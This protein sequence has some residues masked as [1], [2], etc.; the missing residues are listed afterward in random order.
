MGIVFLWLMRGGYGKLF[1][2]EKLRTLRILEYLKRRKSCTIA[3]LMAEFKVSS[4]TIH[5]DVEELSRRDAVERVR[6][7]LVFR[8]APPSRRGGAEFA[9][10]TVTNHAAKIAVARKALSHVTEGDILFL[11]SSTTVYELAM[12]L[13]DADFGHL[14]IVTNSVSVIQHFR[15]FPAHWVLIGLGGTYDP[16]L[17]SILG[18]DALA[19]VSGVNITKAF[20]SAFGLAGQIVTTNHERQAELIRKVI[21]SAEKNYLL[22]DKSKIG[23]TGL[24]RLASRSAFAEVFTA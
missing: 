19:Q 3:E 13:R 7:G 17:N 8:D 24:Y 22:L 6:G 5:R 20:F 14:T 21:A 1:A 23:R 15:D 10:R 16:Q 9:E 2:M 18:A 11:D 12:Q 4:A